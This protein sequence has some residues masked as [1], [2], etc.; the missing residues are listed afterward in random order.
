MWL[1]N[2][3]S[4]LVSRKEYHDYIYKK[5]LLT[6]VISFIWKIYSQ[7]EIVYF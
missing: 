3:S 6:V 1:K 5:G 7:K 2:A 4:L